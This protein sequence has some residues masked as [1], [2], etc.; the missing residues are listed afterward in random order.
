M[1]FLKK[2]RLSEI[3]STKKQES[4][5]LKIFWKSMKWNKD[6]FAIVTSLSGQ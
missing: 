6:D 5:Q 1:K 4:L 3:I 2:L